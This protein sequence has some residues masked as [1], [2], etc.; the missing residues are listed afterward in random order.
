MDGTVNDTLRPVRGEVYRW[1]AGVFAREPTAGTL[2]TYRSP[3]A[4]GILLDLAGMEPLREGAAGF[5]TLL[6]DDTDLEALAFELAG[7]YA[8]LFLGAGGPAAVSPYES[9]HTSPQH[10]L[11]QQATTDMER[12]LAEHG[13]SVAGAPEPADHIAVELEF[14]ALLAASGAAALERRLLDEHLLRWAPAFCA[15]CIERDPGGYYAAAARV[16]RGMLEMEAA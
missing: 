6:N 8:R 3:E 4:R 7:T 10:R 2:A 13:L 11:F 5:L 1:L 15:A 14:L 9:V 12:L 16:L